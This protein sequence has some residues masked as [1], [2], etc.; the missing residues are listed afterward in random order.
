[1]KW[2]KLEY[3]GKKLSS[4]DNLSWATVLRS[5]ELHRLGEI[6]TLV[7]KRLVASRKCIEFI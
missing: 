2:L 4:S 5:R 6:L 3:G 7:E 1:M